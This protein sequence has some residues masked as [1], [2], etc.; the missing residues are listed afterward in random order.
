MV[1]HVSGVIIISLD[2]PTPE[3]PPHLQAL[4][5]TAPVTRK[6]AS[7]QILAS[8]VQIH[9]ACLLADAC[10]SI[11]LTLGD[12]Y[13]SERAHCESSKHVLRIT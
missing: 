9:E 3:S 5:S 4:V 6:R 8:D 11:M 10:A 1:S 2:I 13:N 7:S 12:R